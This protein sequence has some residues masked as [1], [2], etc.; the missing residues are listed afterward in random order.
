MLAWCC[1]K[2]MLIWNWRRCFLTMGRGHGSY[3]VS[4]SS[5]DTSKSTERI[6]SNRRMLLRPCSRTC[7]AALTSQFAHTNTCNENRTQAAFGELCCK[8]FYLWAQNRCMKSTK[9]QQLR[10]L[11]QLRIDATFNLLSQERETV[12]EF[13]AWLH[14]APKTHLQK[15]YANWTKA[16]KSQFDYTMLQPHIFRKIL[17]T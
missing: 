5:H 6:S 16:K 4:M 9:K 1:V 17:P 8:M 15:N 10:Y 7:P 2:W 3:P 14:E 12:Q 11:S 13:T